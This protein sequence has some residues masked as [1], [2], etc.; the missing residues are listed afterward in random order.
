[1]KEKTPEEELVDNI[2]YANM[3][4]EERIDLEII[5]AV[6]DAPIASHYKD[7]DK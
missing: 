1:M 5:H 2:E 4:D 6:W 3:S 7:L